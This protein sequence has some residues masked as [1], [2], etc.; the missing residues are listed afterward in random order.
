MNLTTG[1]R[2]RVRNWMPLEDLLP[3]HLPAFVRSPAYPLATG[4]PEC[5]QEQ[6]KVRAGAA[7]GRCAIVPEH[8]NYFPLRLLGFERYAFVGYL[9]QSRPDPSS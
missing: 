4:I 1:I 7:S 9:V 6:G 5:G 3:D 8:L 2:E